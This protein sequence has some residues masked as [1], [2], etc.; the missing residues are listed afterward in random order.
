ME[1]AVDRNLK[2]EQFE[3]KTLNSVGQNLT[4]VITIKRNSHSPS[5]LV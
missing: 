5:F 4:L 1:P 2:D 3:K